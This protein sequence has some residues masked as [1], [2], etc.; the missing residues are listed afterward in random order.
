M[1]EF[2]LTEEM[3][4]AVR[5]IEEGGKHVFVTGKAGSGK[6]TFLKYLINHTKKHCVVAAPTGVAAINAGGVTLHSLLGIPFGPI[7]PIERLEHRYTEQR[8]EM[9]L[10]LELLIIDEVSMVRADVMDT[11]DRK[12]RWIRESDE[13]FGGVQLVMFG[14][15]FQL[16]PV[17]K[18]EDAKILSA[19][20]DDFFFFNARVFKHTG[21]HVVELTRIFRQT[22]V[23]FVDILNG[24]RE[25]KA[26]PEQLDHLSE[27]K[28]KK[29]C[30]NYDGQYIHLCTHKSKVDKIN[31][32]MLG[33]EGL[34]EYKAAIKDKFPESS[35]PCDSLL[36]L[37]IGARVMALT[38]DRTAGY[39]NGMLGNVTGLSDKN[40]TVHMDNGKTI[41]FERHKWTN[42]Q[43]ALKGDEIVSEDIG[44]CTQFPLALAWAIT[45]HKSQGLTFDKVALHVARTFAPGQL[46]VALSRCR[47]M[48]GI[49]SDAFITSKMIIPEYAL[50]DFERAYKAEGGYYGKR[51]G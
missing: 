35:M 18:T 40:V 2:I 24:I 34:V 1:E 9:L 32:E 31:T 29:A 25:Y 28:D 14:D 33:K 43:Y 11:V 41:V 38:N 39:Y 8:V 12:L 4:D 3:K 7:S 42:T 50:V 51:V 44:S 13:P 6:T 20:Y 27:L 49:V 46:Y 10:K 36:R 16:P 21:F 37:R 15:L 17:I 5:L 22:D 30:H 47:T 19:F 23:E 45:V 26:T 48:Q